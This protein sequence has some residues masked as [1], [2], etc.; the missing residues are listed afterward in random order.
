[1]TSSTSAASLSFNASWKTDIAA[2]TVRVD[3]VAAVGFW[4][5][6]VDGWSSAKLTMA[7]QGEE[8]IEK[9][10]SPVIFSNTALMIRT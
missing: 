2:S 3:E 5:M 7:K 10:A 1:V 6:S 9:P 4:H 8:G